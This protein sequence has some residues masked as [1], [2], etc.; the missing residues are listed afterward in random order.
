LIFTTNFK[1]EIVLEEN[2]SLSE[3]KSKRFNL[4][5]DDYEAWKKQELKY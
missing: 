2:D 4:D 3:E 5:E 1:G